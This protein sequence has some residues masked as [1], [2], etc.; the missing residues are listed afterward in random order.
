MSVVDGWFGPDGSPCWQ[1]RNLRHNSS[2]R[3]AWEEY[4][5]TR[6]APRDRQ[7]ARGRGP[8]FEVGALCFVRHACGLGVAKEAAMITGGPYVAPAAPVV[9]PFPVVGGGASAHL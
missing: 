7:S 6:P 5:D 3:L 2:S 4:P 1:H 9:G 8:T